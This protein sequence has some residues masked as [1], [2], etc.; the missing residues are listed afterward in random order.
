MFCY[1]CF[2]CSYAYVY[3]VLCVVVL[4]YASLLWVWLVSLCGVMLCCYVSLLCLCYVMLC[5][6]HLVML[7][8][9]YVAALLLCCYNVMLL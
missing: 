8:Y 3:V 5:F 2:V 4:H 6:C 9:G 1:A 7:S